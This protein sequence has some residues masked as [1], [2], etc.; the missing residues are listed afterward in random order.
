MNLESYIYCRVTFE[1]MFIRIFYIVTDFIFIRKLCLLYIYSV[2]CKVLNV[3]YI[4][5]DIFVR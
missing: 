4:M 2:I 3:L 5:K 1:V